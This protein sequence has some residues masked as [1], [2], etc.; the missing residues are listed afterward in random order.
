MQNSQT[1]LDK[2]TALSPEQVVEV[3]HFVEFLTNR[4]RKQEALE[5]LLTLAPSLENAGA[6]CRSEDE[7]LAELTAVRTLRH[8]HRNGS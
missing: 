6:G 5:R 4:V 2:I 7:I 1:L 3:E 8:S